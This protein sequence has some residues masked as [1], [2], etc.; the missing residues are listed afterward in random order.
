MPKTIPAL[1]LLS[2]A[3]AACDRFDFGVPVHLLKTGEYH[4]KLIRVSDSPEEEVARYY[5]RVR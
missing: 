1:L 5:F 2:L 3:A 4:V